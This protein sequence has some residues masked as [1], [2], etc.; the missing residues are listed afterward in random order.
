[1]EPT[2]LHKGNFH[3]LDHNYKLAARDVKNKLQGIVCLK[4]YQAQEMLGVYI[5]PD[6][7]NEEQIKCLLQKAQE[8]NCKYIVDL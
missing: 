3:K 8:V 6:G 2:Q 5:A 4:P 1:M 7:N